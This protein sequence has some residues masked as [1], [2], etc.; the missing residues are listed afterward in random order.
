[1]VLF[2]CDAGKLDEAIELSTE[3]IMLNPSA[4]MYATRGEYWYFPPVWFFTVLIV[5]IVC[6]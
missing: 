2:L 1:M 3:A 5:V 4:I 6:Y